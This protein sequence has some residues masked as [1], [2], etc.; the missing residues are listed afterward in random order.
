MQR[1]LDLIIALDQPSQKRPQMP[2]VLRAQQPRHV[3]AD[4]Y[5]GPAW[6]YEGA[7]SFSLIFVAPIGSIDINESGGGRMPAGPRLSRPHV[8]RELERHPQLLAIR[9]ALVAGAALPRRG[10]GVGEA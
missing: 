10:T 8:P 2:N 3:L 6:I 1:G 9:G 4:T 7:L 5:F